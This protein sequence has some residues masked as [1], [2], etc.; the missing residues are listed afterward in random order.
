MRFRL[1]IVQPPVDACCEE[2]RDAALE[3]SA[4]YG[5]FVKDDERDVVGNESEAA[6][7]LGGNWGAR[8]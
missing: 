8:I 6:V 1:A 5:R 4:S 2:Q 7:C 3:A